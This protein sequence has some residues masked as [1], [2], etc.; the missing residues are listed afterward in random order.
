MGL[1]LM[2]SLAPG[3]VIAKSKGCVCMCVYAFFGLLDGRGGRG[4]YL[5]WLLIKLEGLLYLF[6]NFMYSLS[7]VQL[8]YA[9][10]SF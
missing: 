7:L 4:V 10:C 9:K 5:V 8:A 1:E 2:W 6:T 3:R